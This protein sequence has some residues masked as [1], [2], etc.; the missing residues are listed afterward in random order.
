MFRRLFPPLDADVEEGLR[1]TR[2]FFYFLLLVL[3]FLYGL[4]L[5]TTPALRQPAH[6]FAFTLLM[7]LHGVLH[8]FNPYLVTRPR[9][10]WAY[11]IIQGALAL[12]L[13]LLS[14]SA[15]VGM[16]VFLSLAGESVGIL[17]DWR[18]AL[19]VIAAYLAALMGAFVW[20]WGW[21]S[22]PV[23]LGTGLAMLLFVVIYVVLFVRQMQAREEAQRLLNELETAHEQLAAY[24]QQVESLTIEAERQRMARELHDTLA[25]GLAGVILQ[26][27]ALEAHLE[28]GH[29]E[30]AA[31]I[32]TQVKG[33]ARATLAGARRAIGDLRE[34]AIEPLETVR[35]EV[36]HFTTTTGIPCRLDLSPA[37]VLPAETGE[38]VVRC[39]GEGLANVARHA[40]A[41]QVWVTVV[42][43][44]GR[45][46][47]QVKDDG[48]GFDAAANSIPAGHYGLVGL[49]ERARLAGGKLEI[50]SR[51]GAGT[52]LRMVVPLAT[53]PEEEAA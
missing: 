9:R 52:V 10:L 20:L 36:A 35:R 44:N 42:V 22:V 17:E 47:V 34:Q 30:K 50:E 32:V 31:G 27:E 40:Q 28:R 53:L 7:L 41:S 37:L 8:W 19:P 15:G 4:A 13:T 45:L 6:F 33:R 51:P 29:T 43:E 24:A 49:R 21:Q 26:L 1:Q 3:A 23:W 14:R 11:F 46:H 39:V 2:P 48:T 5:Y 12:A 16:G 38:H 18:R 25:Q